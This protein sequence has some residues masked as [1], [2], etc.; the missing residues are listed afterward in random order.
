[1]GLASMNLFISSDHF[2]TLTLFKSTFSVSS[3]SMVRFAPRYL[4]GERH[5]RSLHDT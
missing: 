3:E 5:A 4:A 1:M 2:L